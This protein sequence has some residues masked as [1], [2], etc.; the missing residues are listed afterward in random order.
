MFIPDAARAMPSIRMTAPKP[1][2]ARRK[3]LSFLVCSL[4]SPSSF[5]ETN[6]GF[7]IGERRVMEA[8]S[9]FPCCF[10]LPVGVVF[11]LDLPKFDEDEPNPI[12]GEMGF[13]GEAETDAELSKSVVGFEDSEGLWDLIASLDWLVERKQ[14]VC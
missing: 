8:L 12:P 7:F 10:L 14:R 3:A 5:S 11:A 13:F 2:H 9:L 4:A 6:A 1:N